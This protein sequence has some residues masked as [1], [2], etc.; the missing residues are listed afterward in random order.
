VNHTRLGLQVG[1]FENLTDDARKATYDSFCNECG[2]AFYAN[3]RVSFRCMAEARLANPL[4]T[5]ANVTGN[6]NATAVATVAPR[7][8]G[9][10]LADDDSGGFPE[11]SDDYGNVRSRDAVVSFSLFDLERCMDGE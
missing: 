7:M 11:V 4:P 6:A 10:L 2:N 9:R 8:G 1:V 3:L 5:I